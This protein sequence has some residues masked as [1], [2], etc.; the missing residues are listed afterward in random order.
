MVDGH[1]VYTV[2]VQDEVLLLL[3]QVVRTLFCLCI[4]Q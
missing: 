2:N 4:D 3:L 1:Y